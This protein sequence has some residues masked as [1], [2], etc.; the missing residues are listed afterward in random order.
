[1]L[2]IAAFEGHLRLL[3]QENAHRQIKVAGVVAKGLDR[4]HQRTGLI[5]RHADVGEHLPVEGCRGVLHRR[6]AQIG[7]LDQRGAPIGRVRCAPHQPVGL[8]SADRVGDA[9]DMHLEAI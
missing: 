8:Q 6:S 3:A 2:R 1:M 7:D 9:G 5:G 4:G